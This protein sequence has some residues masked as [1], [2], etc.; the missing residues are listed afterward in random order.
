MYVSVCLSGRW[1]IRVVTF[2]LCSLCEDQPVITTSL[3]EETIAQQVNTCKHM[4]TIL[5]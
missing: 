2:A 1:F 4:T 5:L 3:L